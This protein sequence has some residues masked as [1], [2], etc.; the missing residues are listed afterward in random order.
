MMGID[1]DGHVDELVGRFDVDEMRDLGGI[2]DYVVGS[3]PSPGVFIF[4]AARDET[5][6][7]YLSLGKLGD[8]PLYSFYVP[9]HLTVLEALLSVVRAVALG[10]A[11]IAPLGAPRVDVITAAKADLKQG[12]VLDGIGGYTVYGL[13]ENH[14]EVRGEGLLPMGLADGC[15]LKRDVARDE[16]IT[17]EDV[18]PPGGRLAHALRAEQDAL[19]PV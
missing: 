3:A 9:Y 15:V 5:Q 14:P 13:C 10:D 17:I 12:T 19:F 7:R 16:I 18:D 11:A 8:G 6:A 4:A 2:V 1:H